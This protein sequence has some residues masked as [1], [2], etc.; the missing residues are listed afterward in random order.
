MSFFNVLKSLKI[1]ITKSNRS[2]SRKEPDYI[3]N[4]QFLFTCSGWCNFGSKGASFSC[5]LQYCLAVGCPKAYK[6]G[7]GHRAAGDV[8]TPNPERVIGKCWCLTCFAEDDVDK[9][10]KTCPEQISKIVK[11][12]WLVICNMAPCGKPVGYRLKQLFAMC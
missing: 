8:L 3:T 11:T 2:V 5:R 12:R 10:E 1:E 6:D 9:S 4:V 7:C